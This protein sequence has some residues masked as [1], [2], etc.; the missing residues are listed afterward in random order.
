M[1]EPIRPALCPATGKRIFMRSQDQPEQPPGVT[2]LNILITAEDAYPELERA[3]L[4]ATREVWAGFRVFDLFTK[5]R[6]DEGR[7]VGDTWFDLIVHVLQK[8]VALHFVLSD[9][10]P[11]IGPDLHCA[12]WQ[13][14]RAFVAAREVAGPGAQLEV[15]NA[16]HSARVG[17]LPRLMLWPTLL[18]KVAQQARALNAAK[19]EDR[20]RRLECLPGLRPLLRQTKSG[21]LKVRKWAPPSLVPGTH[22][23]KIAVFDRRLLCIGGLDLDERRYDDKGH[24]RRRDETWHDVQVMCRGAV[25]TA[26]QS[27]LEEFLDVV[28]DH[29]R[30]RDQPPLLRTLSSRRRVQFPF[31]GPRPRVNELAKAHLNGIAKARQLIYLETQFFRDLRIADALAEA[32][33]RQPD[34][35]LILILPGAPEDVAFQ[36]ATSAD[37]RFGEHL[38]AKC[39]SR[40]QKS[41]GPRAALCSPVRP[42]KS[43]STG[44]DVLN[45][46]PIIYVHAKVSI[47]DD[48]QAIV[49][50][51]NLNARS[52]SWDTEA[53]LAIDDARHVEKLRRRVFR[54]W[55]GRDASCGYY[56]LGT[57]TQHWRE[58]A[59]RN[60]DGAPDARKG[61]LV[62]HDPRP[63]RAFGR[64]LPGVPDAMV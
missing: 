3:F 5:L 9:F 60:A 29:T 24:H 14:R 20:A 34:L 10:D 4:N 32:A 8:G 22:H 7:A 23:Q 52:L 38:Q 18:R 17:L 59:K 39:I 25:A 11:I 27:H 36:G 43:D 12:S 2:D 19:P 48:T 15:I 41:F 45:G 1:I 21:Q 35:G 40:V 33:S 30:P 56:D 44:R 37:A 26:A 62:P 16:I 63:A 28:A 58:Q 51:A 42:V 13:S 54:H 55:L 64:P 31:L 53:G 47:F 61:F 6:S 49:S 46:S 57:A 50:S